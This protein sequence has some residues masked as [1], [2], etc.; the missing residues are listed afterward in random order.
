MHAYIRIAGWHKANCSFKHTEQCTK[1]YSNQR[2]D[3]E[4]SL[5]FDKY[6]NMKLGFDFTC[7]QY[8]TTIR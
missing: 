6:T 8:E 5:L 4:H 7:Y 2:I 3:L 1:Q